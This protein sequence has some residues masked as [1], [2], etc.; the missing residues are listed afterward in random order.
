M[1]MDKANLNGLYQAFTL[2]TWVV[3]KRV[4]KINTNASRRHATPK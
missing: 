1:A 4:A 2:N 3:V